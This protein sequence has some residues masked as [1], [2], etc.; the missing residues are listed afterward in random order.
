MI[1]VVMD[2]IFEAKLNMLRWKYL[3]SRRVGIYRQW[4]QEV[5]SIEPDIPHAPNKTRTAIITIFVG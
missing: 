2:S 3:S 1:E 5:Q 4:A